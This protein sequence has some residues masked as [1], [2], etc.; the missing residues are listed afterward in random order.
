MIA[1]TPTP[2]DNTP[3][4][5]G[6]V[7]GSLLFLAFGALVV[8]LVRRRKSAAVVARVSQPSEMRS[9]NEYQAVRVNPSAVYDVGQLERSTGTA[10]LV[11]ANVPAA[12][13]EYD[14]V[15]HLLSPPIVGG[16]SDY[17]TAPVGVYAG[18]P[19]ASASSNYSA[20]PATLR[21]SH[22]TAAPAAAATL[23]DS[24]YTAAPATLRA[25]NVYEAVDAPL[26]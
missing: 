19:P 26:D 4:I 5:V 25:S 9:A 7:V 22:Y 3:L 17:G 12:A 23:R 13:S 18:A 2:T 11:E 14:R 10:S 21:D 16:S 20:A 1:S 24:H 6:A 15:S 8:F